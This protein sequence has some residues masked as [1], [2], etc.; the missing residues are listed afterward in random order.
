[1]S[2]E[3]APRRTPGGH[4]HRTSIRWE[5]CSTS[6][7]RRPALRADQR[8]GR[9]LRRSRRRIREQEPERPSVRAGRASS[10]EAARAWGLAP[11]TLARRHGDLDAITLKALSKDPVTRYATPRTWP[12]ISSGICGIDRSSRPP[13]ALQRPPRPSAGIAPRR[14]SSRAVGDALG[15]ASLGAVQ[16]LRAQ[17]RRPGPSRGQGGGRGARVPPGGDRSTRALT[18][19]ERGTA[20]VDTPKRTCP[21]PDPRAILRPAGAVVAASARR[22]QSSDVFRRRAGHRGAGGIAGSHVALLGPDSAQ[23]IAANERLARLYMDIRA[24]RR[25]SDSSSMRWS[26]GGASWDRTIRTPG[27]TSHL[28]E[29]QVVAEARA[30][31]A[32]S[33]PRSP[34]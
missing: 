31:G 34:D 11:S 32:S 13:G 18:T 10:V 33:R 19:Q 21:G 29:L 26:G 16:A 6:P 25:P 4:A 17:R 22:R 24:S 2:P 27:A 5:S 9:E 28:A 3:Q 8:T 12:P 30:G 15:F 23:A 20:L 14:P 1:M 7:G